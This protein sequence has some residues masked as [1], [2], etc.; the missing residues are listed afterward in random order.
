[1][2][3]L[4]PARSEIPEHYAGRVGVLAKNIV[5]ETNNARREENRRPCKGS[6]RLH[7]AA[8]QRARKMAGQRFMS[9]L[10]WQTA[11]KAVGLSL[12][13]GAAENLGEGFAGAIRLVRAWLASPGH[14]RNLLDPDYVWIGV[15]VARDKHGK[16]WTCQLFL[17]DD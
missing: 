15:G 3:A 12:S 4:A 11:I 17:G 2:T 9:H 6:R 10:G 7:A 8:R 14:R 5:I 16:V 1:M 13:G